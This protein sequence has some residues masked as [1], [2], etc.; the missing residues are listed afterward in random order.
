[1]AKMLARTPGGKSPAKE[2]EAKATPED[3]QKVAERAAKAAAAQLK[4]QEQ[5]LIAARRKELKAMAVGDLKQLVESKGLEAT[6]K[7]DMVEAMV[8]LEAQAREE[9]RKKA[10]LLRD[11]VVQKKAELDGMLLPVLKEKCVELGIKGTLTKEARVEALLKQWQADDGVDKAILKHARDTR[12]G[13]L[14]GLGAAGLKQLCDRAGIDAYVTEVIV[15]RI[16]RVEQAKGLFGRPKVEEEFV[17]PS[18]TAN[19]SADMVDSFLASEVSTKKELELKKQEEEEL[20]ATKA[21]FEGI[22][23]ADLQK[24]VA[25]AGG[26]ASGKKL[27]LVG[28]FLA[29]FVK[30][31]A[32]AAR[33]D[34]LAAMSPDDLLALLKS[35]GVLGGKDKDK[36]PKKDAMVD[37]FLAHEAKVR[38]DAKAFATKIS[39][40]LAGKEPEF[41]SQTTN[42][43]KEMCAAQNLKPSSSK[44]AMVERLIE[45]LKSSGDIDK[46]VATKSRQARSKQLWELNREA[47]LQLCG[48]YD[49]DP[50]VKAIMVERVVGYEDEYGVVEPAGKRARK[51]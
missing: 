2:K 48:Q 44:E 21:Q 40:V 11:I 36:A 23:M 3:P 30:D 37:A 6:K 47:L 45:N 35:R 32:A 14:K 20:A 17:P 19:Q 24:K 29:I 18:E 15:D 26:D 46:L 34:K 38:E 27:D 41:N 50:C 49:V 13:E 25:K 28:K 42:A 5:Q 22:N 10:E 16:I 7:D 4:A 31:K 43:L 12:L 51:N 8:K 1:M 33:K 9:Q 39:E